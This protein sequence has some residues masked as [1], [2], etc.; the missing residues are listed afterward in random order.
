MQD[1]THQIIGKKQ[2]LFYINEY[3]PG[4]IFF[5]EYGTRMINSLSNIIKNE[6]YFRNYQEIITPNI[7]KTD[8]YKISGHYDKYLSNM[9]KV[10]K[11]KKESEKL[12]QSEKLEKSEKSEHQEQHDYCLKPMNC[13]GHCLVFKSQYRSIK[14]LPI[15]YA[16]FG[17]LHRNELQGALSGLTRVIKFT[18][19]DAHIFCSDDQLMEE[20]VNCIDFLKHIYKIFNLNFTV[21]LS[22]RPDNYCGSIDTWSRAESILKEVLDNNFENWKINEGDGAFYGPKIDIHIQ[23]KFNRSFQCGTIQLDF[24][25]PEKF[26]LEYYDTSNNKHRPIMIHRAIYGSIERFL[27]LMIEHYE[28][29]YPLWLSPRQFIIIP[30]DNS[31]EIITYA[32]NILDQF[33]NKKYYVD[34]DVS[35][36]FLNKKIL[37]Y[38]KLENRYNY[39]IIIGQ[40]EIQNNNISIRDNNNKK[41]FNMSLNDFFDLIDKELKF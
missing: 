38:S 1:N 9:F 12:E 24:V 10:T 2:N 19:D 28:G 7:F 4:S 5:L 29:I 34:I 27:G 20:M 14:E 32:N 18:Q 25:L 21:E 30:I 41:Q 3:S 22:T 40:K 16:D 33:K 17:T 23:D 36:N 26:D 13:P 6:Y 31:E 15:R 8:L 11:H 39:T 35:A 37:N